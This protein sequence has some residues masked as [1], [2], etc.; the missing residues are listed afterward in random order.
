MQ[1]THEVENQPP[2]IGDYNAYTIDRPLAEALAREGGAWGEAAVSALGAVAGRADTH[3]LARKS[4]EYAPRLRTHDRWGRRIDEVEFHDAWHDLL[5]IAKAH[6]VDS[7][8][9]T[10]SRPGAEVVRAALHYLYTQADQG[11]SCPVAMT[12]AA[13]PALRHQPDV[14][15]EWVPR[16]T[17]RVYDRRFVPAAEK[18]GALIG[19]AMT[20]KQGGSD[21]RAN[22]TRAVPQGAGGP[23]GEYA[24]TGHKWFCSAPMCDAF[25]TLA[26]T[27]RGLSCFL[28]PRW[29]PDG[30]LNAV[31]LMRLKD[32]LGN[33]SNASSEIEYAGAWARMVGSEGRGVAT[34]IDMVHHTRLECVVGSAGIMRQALTQ[35]LHHVSHRR[36]FQRRLI[37]QPLMRGVVA[38]LAVEAEATVTLLLRL[39]RGFDEAKRADGADP[40]AAFA[41]IATPIAKYW[42]CKRVTPAVQEALECFGGA[43]YVE[44]APMAR[45]FREAPLNGIWEGSGNVICLDVLRALAREPESREAL[46]G[47][48]ALASGADRR[49]DAALG[50]LEAALAPGATSEAGARLLVERAAILLQAS[51]LLRH[52]PAPVA[53][54]FVETRL[55]D[56]GYCFGTVPPGRDV[57]AVI[58]R[59]AA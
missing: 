17:T 18:K 4:N 45:L 34:I 24:L 26:Y 41:R 40:A 6:A 50:Q 31:R 43:G 14:A 58:E 32:K 8:P 11:P 39:A 21:V 52:A 54:L 48:L 7:L 42:V 38:D 57:D 33:K 36:A 19:M 46:L 25:L 27:E 3:E 51:L 12:Y 16:V 20:E 47:E 37:D 13:V 10:D 56:G 9:W 49:Y 2:P 35:A 53:R 28:V 5:G 22:T 30:T 1:A 23:G 15:A 59:H 55:G 29:R 44:E